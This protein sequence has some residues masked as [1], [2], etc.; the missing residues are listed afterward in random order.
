MTL[1]IAL[2]GTGK[3]GSSLM[4]GLIRS[5]HPANNIWI[6]DHQ[7][8]HCHHFAA[9]WAVHV[10]DNNVDAVRVADAVILAVKP[11]IISAV[12]SEI[13]EVVRKKKP[14]II[15]VAAGI[16]THTI[17]QPLSERV[18]II[19]AMPNTP[20]LVGSGATA[21]YANH[22]VG[23]KD[24]QFA[25]TLFQSV[26]VTAWVEKEEEMDAV[27]AISGSGPAYFFLLME[28]LG[29]AARRFGLSDET[30]QLLITHTALGAARMAIESGH[31]PAVLRQQVT[32]PGGTTEK[33]ISVLEQHHLSALFW[34]A[35]DAAK[36][37]SKELARLFGDVEQ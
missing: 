8:E 14:L 36:E 20:A 13:A 5:G 1:N 15:S 23:E 28:I 30:S 2:I 10:A 22:Q 9:Q 18:A 37:R 24:R 29:D 11:Q 27:T 21:L 7:I 4:A 33:A 26:G 6:S 12:L 19:R 35:L 16:R 25:E 17:Q 3:M 32:S 31:S 34:E